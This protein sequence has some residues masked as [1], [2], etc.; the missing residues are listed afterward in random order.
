ANLNDFH[1]SW[2]AVAGIRTTRALPSPAASAKRFRTVSG[3]AP[4]PQTRTDPEMPLGSMR[5]GGRFS[6]A[7]IGVRLRNR[8]AAVSAR[9]IGGPPMLLTVKTC[10]PREDSVAPPFIPSP[11]AKPGGEGVRRSWLLVT[12]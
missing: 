11:P 2:S 3:G 10:A 7:K 4:G 6:S 5:S 1:A 9:A 12:A 8:H